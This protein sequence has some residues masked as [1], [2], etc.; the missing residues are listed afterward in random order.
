MS[1]FIPKIYAGL[2]LTMLFYTREGYYSNICQIWGFL[3]FEVSN[4]VKSL[5]ALP[6]NDLGA[7]RRKLRNFFFEG[8]RP[9]KK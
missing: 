7:G 4:L 2:P 1:W 9:G 3:I 5:L 8:A 6:L